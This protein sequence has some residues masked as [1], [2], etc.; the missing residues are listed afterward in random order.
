MTALI[1]SLELLDWRPY[2]RARYTGGPESD[3]DSAA[4]TLSLM[5]G[6]EREAGLLRS[7]QG[8]LAR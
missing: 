1:I 3:A 6:G 5:D 4:H 8:C 7:R 2:A